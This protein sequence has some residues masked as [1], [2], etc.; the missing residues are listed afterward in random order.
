MHTGVLKRTNKE[1]D[2]SPPNDAKPTTEKLFPVVLNKN[3]VPIGDYEIVGY[4]KEA[5]KRKDA[6]GTERIVEREEFIEGV[7]KPHNSPGV[8]FGEYV[9]GDGRK[10]NAK[11]WA[12]TTIKLPIEEAKNLVAKKLAERADVIAA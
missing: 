10:T 1:P 12:G 8:G 6:A 7:M 5:V 4:L 2:M 3:Y 11:I 9:N